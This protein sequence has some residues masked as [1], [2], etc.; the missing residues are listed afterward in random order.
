MGRRPL[1][2]RNGPA[3]LN[4]PAA[5][6]AHGVV[7]QAEVALFADGLLTQHS[8]GGGVGNHGSSHSLRGRIPANT[9][10]TGNA[11]TAPAA[12]G[13][14]PR[15]PRI[16]GTCKAKLIGVPSVF[17]PLVCNRKDHPKSGGVPLHFRHAHLG[18]PFFEGTPFPGWF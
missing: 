5:R 10:R 2:C 8:G 14:G 17:D 13:P 6:C 4:G 3:A 9:E 11:V 16:D 18:V 15:S 12:R 7:G 1:C